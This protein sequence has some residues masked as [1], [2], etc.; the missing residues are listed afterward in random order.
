MGFAN[1]I[2]RKNVAGKPLGYL[3]KP[4]LALSQE[5]K[6]KKHSW[7]INGEGLAILRNVCRDMC[8]FEG[9]YCIGRKTNQNEW[10]HIFFL[11]VLQGKKIFKC[12][13]W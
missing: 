8:T 5:G 4:V 6:E 13:R 1:K 12:Q 11:L 3:R 10:T 9:F 2:I 7:E